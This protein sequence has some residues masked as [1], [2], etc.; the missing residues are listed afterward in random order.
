[1]SDRTTLIYDGTWEGLLSAV[2][3][4]YSRRPMPQEIV[5]PDS[6]QH[7]AVCYQ[8][9]K[10]DAAKAARVQRGIRAKLGAEAADNLWK[11]FLSGHPH[12]GNFIYHYL[13]LG[14]REGRLVVRRLTD[15][16]VAAVNKQASLVARE[17]RHLLQFIRL[18]ETETGVY[19]AEITPAYPV[20][21]LLMPHFTARMNTQAFVIY[22]KTHE[23][24]GL[25][26]GRHWTVTDAS[27]PL[28]PTYT[29]AEKQYRQLWKT[30]YDTIAITERINP[31]LRQNFMPKKYWRNMV[32][33]TEAPPIRQ[34][35]LPEN[36]NSL[37]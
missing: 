36:K 34:P 8:F 30:F 22:D 20:L 13:R 14:F 26:N 3:A 10:T 24:A 23:Q 35:V 11:C 19:Y 33:M 15:E 1:M 4:A 29:Q 25:W 7:F 31:K 32:E 16:R 6:Q 5:E 28:P 17:A 27:N 2:F 12:R 21:P 9:V 18:G 37:L